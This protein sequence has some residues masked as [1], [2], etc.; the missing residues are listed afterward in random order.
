MC[1]TFCC[2]NHLEKFSVTFFNKSFS[3][4]MIDL[5]I[6]RSPQSSE[7]VANRRI[8]NVFN[9][10]VGIYD[11][12]FRSIVQKKRITTKSGLFTRDDFKNSVESMNT[13]RQEACCLAKKIK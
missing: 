13:A 5:S 8:K 7:I 2:R 12:F 9:R 4:E 3:K 6:N 10:S 1:K 11:L